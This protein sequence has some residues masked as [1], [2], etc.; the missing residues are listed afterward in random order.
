MMDEKNDNQIEFDE[1]SVED[2]LIEEEYDRE[3]IK[4]RRKYMI[5]SLTVIIVFVFLIGSFSGLSTVFNLPALQFVKTSFQLSQNQEIQQYKKAVV[6]IEGNN[7]KGTGFNI[8]KDGLV[9]TNFHVIEKM[10]PIVVYFS[11][12]KIFKARLLKGY[13]EVDLAFLEIEG[14]DLPFLPL[15]KEGQLETG[16]NIFVIGNPLGYYQIANKGERLGRTDVQN[17]DVPVLAISAPVY[18]GNSGSPV[19]N[20][21]GRVV[22]VVFATT[23][24]EIMKGEERAGLAIPIEEVITRMR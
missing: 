9:I 2:F 15:E 16:G 1:P 23:V 12:G 5:R 22:G 14:K 7:V 10:N 4:K 11:D 20:E 24:P 3:P 19:I 6:A 18:R 13:P 17:I 8:S 21:D